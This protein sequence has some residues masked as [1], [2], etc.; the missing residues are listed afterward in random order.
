VDKEKKPE[1]KPP[2]EEGNLAFRMNFTLPL[3]LAMRFRREVPDKKRSEIVAKLI[4]HYLD[5]LDTSKEGD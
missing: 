2:L 5:E 1:G 3:S 4:E